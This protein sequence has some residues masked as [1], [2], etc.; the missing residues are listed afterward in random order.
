[1]QPRAHRTRQLIFEAALL[2]LEQEGEAALT[3]NRIAERSGF[4]VGTIYQYFS[5]KQEILRA[6]VAQERHGR[7]TRIAA[8]LGARKEYAAER[9]PLTAR[10]SAI[11]RI[12]LDAFGGR[13]RARRI[14]VE[15]ALRGHDGGVMSRPVEEIAN[16]LCGATDG[17]EKAPALSAIEAFVLAQAVSG[18]IHAALRRD[19]DL[20]RNP[21]LERALV[22][23]TLG[24]LKQRGA[25]C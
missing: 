6:L 22:D 23:L 8:E 15:Q 17:P 18:V 16:M 9:D 25:G 14:L 2:I 7:M 3:T 24:F 20:L 1:M 4:S 10:V 12:V 19:P 13:H 5:N 11:L 21:G